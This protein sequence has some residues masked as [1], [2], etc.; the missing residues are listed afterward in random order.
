MQI[1]NVT[2]QPNFRGK[3]VF[4][5]VTTKELTTSVPESLW[6][7]YKYITTLI[8]EKPYDL[9]ISRN[10]Q[11]PDFYNIAANRSLEEANKI[12]EYTVKVK[13]NAFAESIIDAA[14][15]AMNM[16]EK[17]IQKGIG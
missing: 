1:Q 17:Y 2:N 12:K 14:K 7:K 5:P 16:Y 8:S 13:F 6:Y 4:E 10:K 11:N 3:V 9:F 15:D